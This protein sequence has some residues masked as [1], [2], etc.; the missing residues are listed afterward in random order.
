MAGALEIPIDSFSNG[1]ISDD[2]EIPRLHEADGRGMMGRIEQAAQDRF[3]N[4]IGQELRTDVS[5]L[6]DRAVDGASFLFGEI[7]P[8]HGLTPAAAVP[9][10]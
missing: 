3:R 2:D 7:L 10:R 1:D 9:L 6:I 8:G 5:P 4:G